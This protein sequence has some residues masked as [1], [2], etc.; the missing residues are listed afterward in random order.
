ML[1]APKTLAWWS[2]SSTLEP[3]VKEAEVDP[4]AG[5][6][7][8]HHRGRQE[9][10]GRHDLRRAGHPPQRVTGMRGYPVHEESPIAAQPTVTY[11]N[12]AARVI[13]GRDRS[14]GRTRRRTGP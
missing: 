4:L 3:Q 2:E 7:S 14:D 12:D 11:R 8:E 1:T 5:R 9:E 13:P 10:P 6:L